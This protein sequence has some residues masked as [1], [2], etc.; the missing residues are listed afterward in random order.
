[1][2]QH[3]YKKGRLRSKQPTTKFSLKTTDKNIQQ[4]PYEQLVYIYRYFAK[5][6]TFSF[7]C[8]H[9]TADHPI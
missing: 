9:H 2:E 8:I 4:Q 1:M 7:K 6:E 3:Q 5:A